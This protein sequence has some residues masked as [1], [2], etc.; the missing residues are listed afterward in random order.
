MWRGQRSTAPR[1]EPVDPPADVL[2]ALSSGQLPAPGQADDIEWHAV[3]EAGRHV[4][5][6]IPGAPRATDHT[7]VPS[8]ELEQLRCIARV[9]YGLYRS[10]HADAEQAEAAIARV[11][12]LHQPADVEFARGPHREQGE[13]ESVRYVRKCCS[14]CADEQHGLPV[15]WPCSTIRVLDGETT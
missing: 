8:A 15:D 10:A 12:A 14:H 3:D 11:R 1:I 5:R 7:L 2:D 6:V 4:I 13:T 9:N